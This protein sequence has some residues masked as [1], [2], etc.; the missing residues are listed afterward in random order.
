MKKREW[1]AA[2]RF[3]IADILMS[4][5]LRMPN[6]LGKLENYGALRAYV[7]RACNRPAFQ[8]AHQDQLAHFEAADAVRDQAGI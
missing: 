7:A 2:S 6:K 1:L 4:D 3:T 5:A 8:K